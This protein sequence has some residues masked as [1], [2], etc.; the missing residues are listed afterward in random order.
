MKEQGWW[1]FLFCLPTVN[2]LSNLFLVSHGCLDSVEVAVHYL[3]II[4]VLS[5]GHA[6]CQYI[7]FFHV[8]KMKLQN[9]I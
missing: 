5:R 3:R 7:L 8:K 6:L 2:Q 9:C 1:T 4:V